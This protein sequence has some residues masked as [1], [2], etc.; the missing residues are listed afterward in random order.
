[1]PG[2]RQTPCAPVSVRV[3]PGSRDNAQTGGSG[4]ERPDSGRHQNKFR[5][6]LA[7]EDGSMPRRS[8]EAEPT[9]G[10]RGP[11]AASASASQVRDRACVPGSMSRTAYARSKAS[12]RHA[13]KRVVTSA[14]V[15]PSPQMAMSIENAMKKV[16]TALEG[17]MIFPRPEFLLAGTRRMTLAA[18][19]PGPRQA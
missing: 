10:G 13:G 2:R 7:G 15:Q 14:R 16:R 18:G 17:A 11:R 6:L 12:I 3:S 4:R 8:S 1:M 9:D 19:Q 5:Q